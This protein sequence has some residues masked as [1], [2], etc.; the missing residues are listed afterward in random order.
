MAEYEYD[1]FG[2]V[3]GKSGLAESS[4]L[5]TNQEFDSESELY[6][7]NARY[8]NPAIGRFISRDP[9][10][11]R[12]GD[13]L[14]KNSYIYVK[15]NPLKYTDP[16]GETEDEGGGWWD[17][18]VDFVFDHPVITGIIIGVAVGAIIVGGVYIVGGEIVCGVLCPA[19]IEVGSISTAVANRV[20]SYLNDATS[21]I[22][23]SNE[24]NLI[25]NAINNE[26][27][28]NVFNKLYQATDK[29]PGGTAGSLGQIVGGSNHLQK[30]QDSVNALWKI[31][32]TPNLIK[33]DIQI[34]QTLLDQLINAMTKLK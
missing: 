3:V 5:F 34:A 8:Y 28:R 16:T 30:A 31:I 1:V 9:M 2:S 33:S 21:R 24:R 13:V 25:S 15:N 23:S 20:I 6:Y 14:S 10:L 18:L 7:Y 27:L 26:K 11:G 4:Y 32:N 19:V 17:D 12:D 29:I 22:L